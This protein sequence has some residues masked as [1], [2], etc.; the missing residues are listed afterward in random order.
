[1]KK[2]VTVNLGGSVF[3]IDED[4]YQLLNN[5][6]SNL[7]LYYEHEQGGNEIVH[8]LE[9]RIAEHF[10]AKLAKGSQVIEIAYVKEVIERMGNPEEFDSE[11]DAAHTSHQSK[12]TTSEEE[13]SSGSKKTYIN[14]KKWFRDPD[15]RILGGVCS[16]LSAYLGWDV[17]LIRIAFIV[18]ALLGYGAP[19]II[20]VIAMI[21]IPEAK[22]ATDKLRM[23]GKMVT[24]ESIGET[25]RSGYEQMNA[26]LKNESSSTIKKVF[27]IVLAIF[28]FP[29]LLAV[30][31][32]VGA[33]F[34]ALFSLLFAGG[35]FA[36][37]GALPFLANSS[38][39]VCS[40]PLEQ[41][42][43]FGSS[44]L[45]VLAIPLFGFLFALLRQLFHW[46]PMATWVKWLLL[47]LWIIAIFSSGLSFMHSFF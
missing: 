43:L 32:A 9:T 30:I 38:I 11:S 46:K 39:S 34:I 42:I 7:H 44:F 15:N 18:F 23:H 28:C 27:L 2:T 3:C 45:M 10:N 1:M 24:V 26:H 5:Y 8:D 37:L 33:L 21:V 47:L 40:L 41:N 12:S 29:L 36:A 14:A 19:L 4:A 17:T 16:G 25:V 35:S 20:Y 31:Y 6:L 13:E 22:T